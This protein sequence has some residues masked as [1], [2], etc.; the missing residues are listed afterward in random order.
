MDT[1][2]RSGADKVSI[3]TAAVQNPNVIAEAAQHFG[4][5]CVVLAIDARRS[6]EHA[7]K[8]QVCVKAGS[9]PTNID[10]V[11]WAVKTEKLGAGEILLTSM[12]ADGTKAGYDNELN[13]A[14]TD[15][16]NI[17]V[18]A[19][20]G[21]GTPE[22]LYDAVVDGSVD[23]VLMASITHFRNYTIKQMKEYLASRGI[24]VN[25]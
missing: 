25:L 12:D 23:A 14:V 7:H 3:N 10:V 17:P 16:V 19:S 22:H 21:A 6:K 1:I 20:G 8:W 13:K 9:E 11:E 4:S 18:I 24:P 5:Q 2:L 15:A